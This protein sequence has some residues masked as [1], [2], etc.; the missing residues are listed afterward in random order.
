MKKG[1]KKATVCFLTLSA[2]IIINSNKNIP[3]TIAQEVQTEKEQ[4]VPTLLDGIWEN[5]SRYI[6][7]NTGYTTEDNKTIPQ[8]VL[9]I[10]YQWYDDRTAESLDY[11]KEH[12]RDKNNTTDPVSSP[13]VMKVSFVP[14]TDELLTQEQ[15]EAVVQSDGDKLYA[16]KDS[17]GAWDMQVTYSGP[18]LGGIKVYHIP[19]AVIGNKLY[20]HFAIK[21]EDSDSV[22]VSSLLEGNIME[23][24]N[25]LAGYWQ[26]YGSSNGILVSPSF[27]NDELLCYYITD[28]AVYKLRYWETDMEYDGETK[29]TFTDGNDVFSVPRH[30]RA[31]ER[32]FTCTLGRRTKIN[33]VEKLS[34]LDKE[35]VLNSVFVQKE[36]KDANGNNVKYTVRTSTICAFG[37]PYLTLH[38]GSESLEEI[39]ASDNSRKKPSPQPLFPPHGVLDFD[40]SI[41]E[42]PPSSWNRRMLDLGK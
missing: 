13:T 28:N 26:D 16:E 39:I 31:A 9:R 23:S 19:V 34:E 17:S 29:A 35:Y 2:C 36:A 10:F 32:T 7:F 21:K 6:V 14:L 24:G 20:L 12:S 30:I 22:P 1:F 40:W 11:A 15:G 5:Y 37:E 33:N 42:D 3:L 38:N 18:T 4:I 25:L 8:I 27:Q 41:I